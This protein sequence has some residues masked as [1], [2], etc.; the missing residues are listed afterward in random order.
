M[1]YYIQGTDS[2]MAIPVFDNSQYS[3]PQIDQTYGGSLSG[4]F[5]PIN[6]ESN[7]IEQAL[8]TLENVGDQE[9][10]S[11]AKRILI[12]LQEKV[13]ELIPY[14]IDLY[15]L[16]PIRAAIMEDRSVLLEWIYDDFRIGFSVEQIEEESGWY[17]VTNQKYGAISASGY[18]SLEN[19]VN[20]IRW[21]LSFI[22]LHS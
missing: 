18:I 8:R 13:N 12:S 10:Y 21:I 4:K 17:L 9:I 14:R 20:T 15:Y 16:P 5:L 6:I 11:R 7:L 3:I 19:F 2:R 1:R 22:I